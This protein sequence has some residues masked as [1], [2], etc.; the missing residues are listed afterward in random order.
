[1]KIVSLIIFFISISCIYTVYGNN[2]SIDESRFV[3]IA[4][5]DHWISIRGENRANPV[6]LVL[7]GGPGSVLSPYSDSLFKQWYKDFVIVNWDQRGAG[8]TFGKNAPDTLA[9]D[10][11]LKEP[12][13]FKQMLKDGLELTKYITRYLDKK[14]LIVLGGSWGSLLGLRMVQESPSLFSAY[15]SS[16]QVVSFPKNYDY[17]YRYLLKETEQTQAKEVAE[18]LKELGPPPYSSPKQLG[19]FLRLLRHWERRSVQP[20][21]AHFWS[22]NPDYDTPKDQKHRFMGDDYSFLYFSGHEKLGIRPL[23]MH[24]D[25]SKMNPS[26]KVP[27][28][29]VSGEFDILTSID[30][31]KPWFERIEA[32]DKELYIVKGAGHDWSPSI[33]QKQLSIVKKLRQ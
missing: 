10:Y 22:M 1:M 18:K 2:Q 5:K 11:F 30:V 16:A 8:K 25:F 19:Q 29:F 20:V 31:L 17:A 24:I 27:L 33:L 4:G 9:E 12:L 15:V 23:A 21:T 28:Y 32:P 26:F 7:H 6:I 14:Q 3:R 13:V